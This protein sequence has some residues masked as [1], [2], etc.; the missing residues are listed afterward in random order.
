MSCIS[1]QKGFV[2]L[3][4]KILCESHWEKNPLNPDFSKFQ[5]VISN[6]FRAFFYCFFSLKKPSFCYWCC[7]NWIC[8]AYQNVWHL[9]RA[10][11]WILSSLLLNLKHTQT[12]C[13][14]D[15]PGWKVTFRVSTVDQT[16]NHV[17]RTQT[18]MFFSKVSIQEQFLLQTWHKT[19]KVFRFA[20]SIDESW[21]KT[22]YFAR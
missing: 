16:R 13:W 22:L 7:I 19:R 17:L 5:R 12:L 20:T 11:I 8:Q 2:G 4:W 14:C 9:H 18:N 3:L 10:M 15:L 6:F 1:W 21:K